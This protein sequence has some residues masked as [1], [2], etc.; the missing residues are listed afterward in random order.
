MSTTAKI[1]SPYSVHPGVAMVQKW[2]QGA[3]AEDRTVAGRMDCAHKKV[4]A[5]GGEKRREWLKKEHRF[6]HK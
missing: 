1:Q 6:G 5:G 2:V 3:V 4:G